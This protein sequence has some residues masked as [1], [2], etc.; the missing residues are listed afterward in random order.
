MRT[1][2][3]Y[4]TKHGTAEKA[5]RIL[6]EKLKGE[7]RLVNL[8]Q[9]RNP[10]LSGFDT[11]IIGGSIHIGRIQRGIK[12]F[13]LK[14]MKT[15]LKKRLGLYLCCMEEGEGACRQ[16]NEAF[17][18]EL[19]GHAAAR[20]HFGG[21]FYFQRMNFIERAIIRK[22]A[23]IEENISRLDQKAIDLF[24]DEIMK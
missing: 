16:F 19:R 6:E 18:E 22:I 5:A 20:G 1:L 12:N 8:K 10:D 7:I 24:I 15:L 2:I 9:N 3:I 23:N 4:M 14:N 21:E 17:P 13:A 11:V